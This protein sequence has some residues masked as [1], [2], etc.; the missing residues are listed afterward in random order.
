[1]IPRTK[2]GDCSNTECGKKETECIKVGKDL[3]CINCRNKQ[4]VNKQLSKSQTRA[5]SNKLYKLQDRQEAERA[6]LIQDLDDVFSKYIRIREAD[7]NGIV[8]CY[9]CD[10]KDHWKKL[11][12]S[13]YISRKSM[14]L[15]WDIRNARPAC[16]TCNEFLQGNIEEYTK[17]LE[18]ECPGIT[19]QLKE[20]SRDI[21]K[22]SKEDLK[23]MVINFREKLKLAQSR[24]NL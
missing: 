13:H 21:A 12:C 15:R 22:F 3:F 6:Y 23:H 10:K 9:T 8:V 11:Q 19:N 16:V 1:M 18:L 20:E 24:F 17:R 2:F 5:I 4:K 14:G 7:S